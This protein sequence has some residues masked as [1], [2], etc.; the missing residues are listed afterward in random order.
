MV[1]ITAGMDLSLGEFTE[2]GNQIEEYASENATIVIGT[3][4]EPEM[5]EEIKVTVV[6]TGL[7]KPQETVCAL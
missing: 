3:V 1:N 4:I 5:S 7:D 2:V 6:A